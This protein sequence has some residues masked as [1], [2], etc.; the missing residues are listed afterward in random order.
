MIDATKG[1]RFFYINSINRISGTSSAFAVP[2]Q[3]PTNEQYDACVVTAVSIPISYYLIT[4]NYNTFQLQEQNTIVTITIPQGNYNINSFCTVVAALLNS[5]SPFHYTYSLTYNNSFTQNNNGL[6]IYTVTGN[7]NHQ[8]SLIMNSSNFLYEQFGFANG[9]T[10]VFSG[11]TLTS[12]NIVNFINEQ[13]IYI[14]SDIV[15]NGSDNILQEIYGNNSSQLSVVTYQCQDI[16]PYSKS[17]TGF[18]N[19]VMNV[20]LTDGHN[21][22]LQLSQDMQF[23]LLCY[24]SNVF[25]DKVSNFVEMA[26]TFIMHLVSSD[27]SA[28]GST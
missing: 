15:N 8:P 4:N 21:I 27:A 28:N 11:N 22:P 1:K 26:K 19:Q 25:L 6:I 12:T 17:F 18:R 2:I 14:H 5:N 3:M 24:K 7:T 13:I 16:V 9:S 23:T 10:N 20:Y